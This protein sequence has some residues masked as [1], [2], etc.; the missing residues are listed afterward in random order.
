MEKFNKVMSFTLTN[1]LDDMMDKLTRIRRTWKRV[2][3][4]R[5]KSSIV[6]FLIV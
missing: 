2:Q 3:K 6:I 1:K 4:G 5:N